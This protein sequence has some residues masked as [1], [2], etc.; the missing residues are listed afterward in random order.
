MVKHTQTVRR[1]IS[2]E[3]SEF[4]TTLKRVKIRIVHFLQRMKQYKDRSKTLQE[5]LAK[6][7]IWLRRSNV[8]IHLA[9]NSPV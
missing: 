5:N 3:L 6:V 8:F 2:D 1:Q 7:D 4:L 9:K